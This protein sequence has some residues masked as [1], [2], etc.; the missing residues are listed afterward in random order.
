VLEW[1]VYITPLSGRVDQKPKAFNVFTHGRFMEDVKKAARKYRDR[2][3]EQFEEQLRRELMYYF[4]SKCEWEIVLTR[5]PPFE[6]SDE[7]FNRTSEKVDVYD[8]VMLNWDRFREYVWANRA[9]LRRRE[10]ASEG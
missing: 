7:R 8:Q 1:Y 4:W 2:E 5:W 9:E 3:R 6:T 10:K